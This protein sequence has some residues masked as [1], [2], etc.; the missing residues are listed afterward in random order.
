MKEKLE[1]YK[2]K[3]IDSEFMLIDHIGEQIDDI[4]EIYEDTQ[5]EQETE[6]RY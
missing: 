4:L 2:K 6:D 1:A 3:Y 5:L